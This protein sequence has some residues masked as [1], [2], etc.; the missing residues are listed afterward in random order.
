MS[1]SG[2]HL[3]E[4]RVKVSGKP[5]YLWQ[6]IDQDGEVLDFCVTETGERDTALVILRRL[7][8]RHPV[9]EQ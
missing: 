8:S 1:K 5:R 2:W 9:P 7:M 4:T 3:E 6:A